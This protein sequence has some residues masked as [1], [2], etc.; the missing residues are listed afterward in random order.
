MLSHNRLLL[1][2][3]KKD[4]AHLWF[5]EVLPLVKEHPLLRKLGIG[6]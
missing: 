1:L 3:E 4:Q 6:R 5:Q 2:Q